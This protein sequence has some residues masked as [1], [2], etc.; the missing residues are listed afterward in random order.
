TAQ[1]HIPPTSWRETRLKELQGQR[2]LL[3]R[4]YAN[5]ELL[6]VLIAPLESEIVS[7]QTKI[8]NIVILKAGKRW[9][10]DNEKSAGYLKRRANTRQRKRCAQRFTHPSTGV[11]CSDPQDMIDAATD[12]CES[13]FQTE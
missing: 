2:N 13:L 8:A 10:E 11:D 9:L 12:F 6:E 4:D 7:L 3:Y 5:T 1:I